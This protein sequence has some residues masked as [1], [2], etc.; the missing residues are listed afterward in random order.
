MMKKWL[1]LVLTAALLAALFAVSASAGDNDLVQILMSSQGVTAVSAQK[2]QS[3]T[4][5][6]LD[7]AIEA[8]SDLIPQGC[9]LVPG[10]VTLLDARCLSCEEEVYDVSFKVWSTVKRTVGLFFRAEGEEAWQLISC[11]L[12]DVIEGRFECSGTCAIAVGW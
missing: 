8:G 1:A 3:P 10:R 7:D 6:E 2:E 9:K 5:Q 4:A 12:G 11:N